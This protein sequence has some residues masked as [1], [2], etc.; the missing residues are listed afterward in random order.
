MS[1]ET[2]GIIAVVAATFIAVI[3]SLVILVR[4]F[5]KLENKVDSIRHGL[6]QNIRQSNNVLGLL[7]TLI[8][9]LSRRNT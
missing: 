6:N 5:D 7:S 3:S 4:H 1:F 2:I 9:L 8:G